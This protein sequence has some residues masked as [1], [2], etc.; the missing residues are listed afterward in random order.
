MA[1]AAEGQLASTSSS[2]SAPASSTTVRARF[3]PRSSKEAEA[4]C[5]EYAGNTQIGFTGPDGTRHSFTFDKIYGEAS[6]QADV[7]SD[8]RPVVEAALA[9]YNGTIMAYGQTGSGKTHSL[10]GRVA[11]PEQHGVV[12]RAIAHLAA[13]IAEAGERDGADFQVVLSVVEI[14][15]ERIRDLLEPSPGAPGAGGGA[16]TADNL[17]VKQDAVRGVYIEGA[18]EL[19]VTDEQQLVDFMTRGLAQRAVSATSMNEAS[20]RSHCIVTVRVNRTLPDGT[21][22]VGKLVMVD[23]AGSE[24][25]DRTHAAGATLVEGSLINK[26]LSCLSNVIY[27]LTEDSRGGKARHVPYRDSK[28]TRVLQDSLGGSARTVLIICCSPC[29]ENAAETLSSLRFGSRAKGVQNTVTVNQRISPERL[30][31]QLEQMRARYAQLVEEL[32]AARALAA[33]RMGSPAA[34]PPP[35]P[36][37]PVE[38]AGPSGSGGGAAG[39]GPAGAAA[40]GGES[41]D[42]GREGGG[43][44]GGGG[45]NDGVEGRGLEEEIR[46]KLSD[47]RKGFEALFRLVMVL[48]KGGGTGSGGGELAVGGAGP[49]A[50]PTPRQVSALADLSALAVLGLGLVAVAVWER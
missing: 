31:Q 1:E 7:F 36:P 49:L 13:G 16:G 15:C 42:A 47:G 45:G 12:P 20:S 6:S 33:P 35:P 24:R 29:L 8:L 37:P 3:R 18:T 34:A 9:G 5:V 40:V 2:A 43:G 11:D 22:Q 4:R 27:A 48:V 50:L 14:Y 30:Q 19:G 26:S 44:S 17:Q 28:L 21:V 38:P 25:A 41:G 32:A 23:L 46:A 10:I 39:G